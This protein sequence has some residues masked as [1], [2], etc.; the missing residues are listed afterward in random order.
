MNVYLVVTNTDYTILCKA[1][2][3]EKAVEKANNYYMNEFGE[4]RD[5][6]VAYSVEEWLSNDYSGEDTV[7]IKINMGF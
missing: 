1:E 6:W 2:S 5:D 7:P 4:D 3:K